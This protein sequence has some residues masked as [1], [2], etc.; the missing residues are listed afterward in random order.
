MMRIH[1]SWICS[2][3]PALHEFRSLYILK[4]ASFLS[5]HFTLALVRWCRR[6]WLWLRFG[7]SF[8]K[9]LNWLLLTWFWFLKFIIRS[10]SS[11]WSTLRGT[12]SKLFI[13]SIVRRGQF[14]KYCNILYLL[15]LHHFFNVLLII[16]LWV[17]FFLFF[18]LVFIYRV[19]IRRWLLFASERFVFTSYWSQDRCWCPLR[20][21]KRIWVI[22]IISITAT[23]QH[24]SCCISTRCWRLFRLVRW[25]SWSSTFIWLLEACHSLSITSISVNWLS[26]LFTW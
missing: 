13:A 23:F 2:H 7:R 22:L 8:V 4:L 17:V 20:L 21:F 25:W 1:S 16:L 24:F 3:H 9:L 14:V 5:F 19:V 11:G 6:Y 26:I 12:W 10:H 18:L 15:I